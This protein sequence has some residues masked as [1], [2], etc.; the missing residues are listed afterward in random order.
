METTN[1]VSPVETTK[2]GSRLEDEATHEATKSELETRETELR[3]RDTDLVSRVS[4]LKSRSE[5]LYERSEGSDVRESELDDR[6]RNFVDSWTNADEEAQSIRA[7]S[8]RLDKW[9]RELGEK[10]QESKEAATRWRGAADLHAKL[11]KE[12]HE[13]SDSRAPHSSDASFR[14]ELMQSGREAEA[15][16][17]EAEALTARLSAEI[18]DYNRTYDRFLETLEKHIAEQVAWRSVATEWLWDRQRH[19]VD[20]NNR[21]A[22]SKSIGYEQKLLQ[23]ERDIWVTDMQRW[24]GDVSDFLGPLDIDEAERKRIALKM[25]KLVW[26]DQDEQLVGIQFELLCTDLLNEIGYSATH[27]GGHDDGGIDV[28][29]TE[30]ALTGQAWI[31][32]IQC[33]YKGANGVVGANEVS[34]F[35]GKLSVAGQYNRALYVTAGAIHKDAVSIAEANDIDFWDG[36]Q[37]FARLIAE[38]VGLEDRIS[39]SGHSI[40]FD[41]EYWQQ[42]AIRASAVR[43]AR[44]KLGRRTLGSA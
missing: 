10:Q 38:G 20:V 22:E 40:Q 4:D 11:L 2:P 39:T 36:R 6:R 5:S 26:D 31:C 29:A 25:D 34:Q 1:G 13:G 44:K 9:R 19:N 15:R 37:L 41:T 35:I 3:A 17:T 7:E 18:D 42:L 16:Q 32:L 12:M 24:R 30:V 23:A 28:R 21:N 33:K 43:D 27:E 8:N 14:R